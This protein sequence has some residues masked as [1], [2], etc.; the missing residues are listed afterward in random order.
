MVT[1]LGINKLGE[2]AVLEAV[3]LVQ[4]PL[5]AVLVEL[6]TRQA[7]APAKAT[8]GEL[9]VNILVQAVVALVVSVKI[10]LVVVQMVRVDLV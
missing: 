7:Q 9:R 3:L 6:E 2:A 8:T 1:A 10:L 5:V 4:C